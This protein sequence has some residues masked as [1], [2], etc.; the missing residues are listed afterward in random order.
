MA[1]LVQYAIGDGLNNLSCDI[2]FDDPP[3]PGNMLVLAAWGRGTA[4]A[5]P[6]EFDEDTRSS[7]TASPVLVL[8]HRVAQV[9]DGETFTSPTG[10]QR[11]PPRPATGSPLA[12]SPR[13]QGPSPRTP[14]AMT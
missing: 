2:T 14:R 6:E 10:P 11:R 9:G 8:G 4:L 13:R 1:T 5:L 7:S 12:A 3:T